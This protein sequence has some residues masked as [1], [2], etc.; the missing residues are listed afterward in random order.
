MDAGQLENLIKSM[1]SGSEEANQELY[2]IIHDIES[3]FLF[4]ECLQSTGDNYVKSVCLYSIKNMVILYRDDL[5]IESQQTLFNAITS[6]IPE[7]ANDSTS[8]IMC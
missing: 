8:Y 5:S 1:Q 2:S 7:E 4:L 6:L 3:I